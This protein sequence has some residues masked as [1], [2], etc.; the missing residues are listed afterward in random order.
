MW[1]NEPSSDSESE[2]STQ[3]EAEVNFS[4]SAGGVNTLEIPSRQV[5]AARC[6][7]VYMPT[8]Y[9]CRCASR[10]NVISWQRKYRRR[11]QRQNQHQPRILART[12]NI[13]LLRPKMST[14]KALHCWVAHTEW[15]KYIKMKLTVAWLSDYFNNR[16]RC[17]RLG[18]M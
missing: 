5:K 10:P 17:T 9:S 12:W 15:K 16:I 3:H 13:W 7:N 4:L 6:E 11:H 18:K 14:R 2:L 1:P 8:W